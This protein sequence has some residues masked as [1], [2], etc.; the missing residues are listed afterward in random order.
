MNDAF[1]LKLGC[2]LINN[3]DALWVIILRG[4]YGRNKNLHGDLPCNPQD[5]CLWKA[6]HSI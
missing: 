6:I 5:S 3:R 4:K 2:G 1:M